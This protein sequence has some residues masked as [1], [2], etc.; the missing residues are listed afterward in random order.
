MVFSDII[1]I[2]MQLY[3]ESM[4]RNT[5]STVSR[6]LSYGPSLVLPK[7]E[8]YRVINPIASLDPISRERER[9]RQLQ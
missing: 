7:N 9:E 4:K 6:R 5:L 1:E 2:K 8:V 3:E